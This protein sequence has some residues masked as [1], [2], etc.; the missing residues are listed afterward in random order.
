MS[1]NRVLGL[2]TYKQIGRFKKCVWFFF[3]YKIKKNVL[4]TPWG[5]LRYPLTLSVN[6]SLSYFDVADE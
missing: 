5:G 1:K 4:L 2:V 6:T 3:N